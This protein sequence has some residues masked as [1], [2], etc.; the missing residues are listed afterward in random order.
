MDRKKISVCIIGCGRIA[1]HHVNA[2]LENGSF[3]LSGVCDLNRERRSDFEKKYRCLVFSCFRAMCEQV[4]PDLVVVA[5]PSGF[6]Y[7]HCLE[8]LQT[9][10]VGVVVEKPPFLRLEHARELL[11]LSMSVNRPIFPVLQNRYNKAV[12]FVRS[13]LQDGAHVLTE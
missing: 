6:H 2:I 13:A 11:T 3:H 9:Y 1:D 8:L 5:T 7:Q 12:S 4:S 10:E